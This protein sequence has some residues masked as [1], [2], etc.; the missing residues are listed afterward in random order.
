MIGI[1]LTL[2]YPQIGS[3]NLFCF[4]ALDRTCPLD[5]TYPTGGTHRVFRQF[6]WLEAGS[7][8]AA[9]PSPAHQYPEGA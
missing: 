7:V 4:R 9:L 6:L 1:S 3:T 5:K 8:K 2:C